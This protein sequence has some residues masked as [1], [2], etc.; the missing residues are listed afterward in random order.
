MAVFRITFKITNLSGIKKG[1]NV[2]VITD[3]FPPTSNPVGSTKYDPV[4][5]K[6]FMSKYGLNSTTWKASLRRDNVDVVK[7]SD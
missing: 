2:E 3:K 5:I 4:I 1:M 6:E 7:I